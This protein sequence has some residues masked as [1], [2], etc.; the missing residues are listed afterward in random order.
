MFWKRETLASFAFGEGLCLGT[1]LGPW[2]PARPRIYIVDICSPSLRNFNPELLRAAFSP[3]AVSL[4][5]G[6]F[7]RNT[8]CYTTCMDVL[9]ELGLD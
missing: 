7:V 1:A 3:N 2:H 5:L 6:R 4:P 8:F 9:R